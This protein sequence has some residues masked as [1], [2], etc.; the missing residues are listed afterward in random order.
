MWIFLLFNV[1][2]EQ[3]KLWPVGYILLRFIPQTLLVA[4]VDCC[5]TAYHL[6]IWKNHPQCIIDG[7]VN[8]QPPPTSLSSLMLAWTHSKLKFISKQS[9][10]LPQEEQQQAK[11]S[12]EMCKF[13]APFEWMQYRS[14]MD[15]TAPNAWKGNIGRRCEIP[16]FFVLVLFWE[17]WWG[18]KM[19]ENSKFICSILYRTTEQ[20]LNST[21]CSITV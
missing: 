7:K 19:I 3:L 16:L 4:N 15:S 6:E 21:V 13:K 9:Y 11:S 5:V 17:G 18:C 20:T 8:T 14:E 12:A 1:I 2:V 10:P